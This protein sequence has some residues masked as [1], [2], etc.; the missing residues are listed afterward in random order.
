M[1]TLV[2][3]PVPVI[4]VAIFAEAVLAVML[5]KSG[6]GVLLGAMA[7]VLVVALGLV[8]L[9]RLVVTDRERIEATLDGCAAALQDNDLDGLLGYISPSDTASR[10]EA[11]R[12]LRLIE[13]SKV[14]LGD[15]EITINRLT[16]PHTAHVVLRAYAAGRLRSGEFEGTMRPIRFEVELR[17]EGDR[18]LVTGHKYDP[19]AGL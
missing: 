12:A 10:T 13:F 5:V 15:P 1:T 7:G 17:Q 11:A 14:T 4:V 6:R 2:E 18:W 9:E 3:N 19:H 16:S 8:G